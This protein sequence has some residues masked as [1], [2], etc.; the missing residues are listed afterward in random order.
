MSV[1]KLA[2]KLWRFQYRDAKM[3]YLWMFLR[4]M[5]S[6]A[7]IAAIAITFVTEGRGLLL[8]AC[9]TFS[10]ITVQFFRHSLRMPKILSIM[11]FALSEKGHSQIRLALSIRFVLEYGVPLAALGFALSLPDFESAITYI[12]DLS[13]A[14]FFLCF[15][16]FCFFDFN[17]LLFRR[18]P[19]YKYA[20]RYL[21]PGFILLFVLSTNSAVTELLRYI[22]NSMPVISSIL[23][24]SLKFVSTDPKFILICLFFSILVSISVY[25]ITPYEELQ[26]QFEE[27]LE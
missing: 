23:P 22:L 15:H 26:D 5:F 4:P 27:Y 25:L 1:L 20:L 9:A 10:T 8:V 21:A 12:M 14:L 13:F 18:V 3:P 16:L 17:F 6:F 24:L 2:W 11:N 19:D 7:P